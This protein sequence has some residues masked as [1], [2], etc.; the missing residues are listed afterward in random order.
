MVLD[1]SVLCFVAFMLAEFAAIAAV[2]FLAIMAGHAAARWASCR[3]SERKVLMEDVGR[4][5]RDMRLLAVNSAVLNTLALN[6][7]AEDEGEDD[8]E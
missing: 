4:L 7:L 3:R 6:E 2:A 5:K 1:F 8:D